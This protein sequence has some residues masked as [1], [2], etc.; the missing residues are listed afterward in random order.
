[1]LVS[2]DSTLEILEEAQRA[3]MRGLPQLAFSRLLDAYLAL[4]ESEYGFIGEISVDEA[5][6]NYLVSR[7]VTNISWDD[8]SR[9]LWRR[10]LG[11]GI[12]FRNARSLFGITMTTGK[13]VIANDVDHDHRA[14]GRPPGHPALLRY[15]GE[16]IFV[17]G[18]L[19]G[20]VGLANR[21]GGYHDETVRLIGGLNLLCS[22]FLVGMSETSLRESAQVEQARERDRLAAVFAALEDGVAILDAEGHAL[23][24]NDAF[25]RVVGRAAMECCGLGEPIVEGDCHC[26]RDVIASFVQSSR[27]QGALLDPQVVRLVVRGEERWIRLSLRSERSVPW[28]GQMVLVVRDVTS[29]VARRETLQAEA[30]RLGAEALRR[31]QALES[32]RSELDRVVR[33]LKA[34][35]SIFAGLVEVMPTAV[36]VLRGDQL[37]QANEA[38]R[39]LLEPVLRALRQHASRA[40]RRRQSGVQTLDVREREE[41]LEFQVEEQGARRLYWLHRRDVMAGDGPLT[42]VVV[43]DV[44]ARMARREQTRRA[45]ERLAELGR[46]LLVGGVTQQLAHELNQPTH[47]IESYANGCL[48]R[49]GRLGLDA[50]ITQALE[51]VSG[52]ALRIGTIVS[53]L[54]NA[55]Q[56]KPM[57]ADPFD[58]FAVCAD[59]VALLAES[60]APIE[61]EL[62]YPTADATIVLDQ[63]LTRL[64]VFGLLQFRGVQLREAGD[65]H[66]R[67]TLASDVE[68]VALTLSDR[69]SAFP[70]AVLATLR[71]EP[72]ADRSGDV[73]PDAFV[74]G[75]IVAAFGGSLR[76]D[77]G[78]PHRLTVRLP[79]RIH[80]DDGG[81][82]LALAVER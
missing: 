17:G 34:S 6:Q 72:L 79:R 67:I 56:I 2:S 47:A 80:K 19:R 62:V 29:E 30:E 33:D 57:V 3:Y 23:S 70:S 43:N 13:R 22:Q 28:S 24:E 63:E 52:E 49:A 48:A 25:A 38:G 27:L 71:H 45:A 39:Q 68:S 61:L 20:M 26:D 14:G 1:M 44:S 74:I 53:R 5:G 15:L 12:E 64:L 65:R 58:F 55:F 54:R 73:D 32:S 76:V 11:N 35:E 31:A 50:N 59:V 36:L 7:A 9:D 51:R 75:R 46:G 4:T 66:L 82:G 37:M 69:G 18:E 78:R 10:T 81:A 40:Q 77:G 60:V 42:M 41:H 8:A 16:P 21:P